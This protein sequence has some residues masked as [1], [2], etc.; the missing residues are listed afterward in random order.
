MIAARGAT[1]LG[2]ALILS[3][4][5]STSAV[6]LDFETVLP[7]YYIPSDRGLA[8]DAAGNS[9]LIASGHDNGS[10]LDVIV[11][12]LNPAGSEIWTRHIVTTDGHST[13]NDIVL[14]AANNPL[15]TGW[16]DADD[17]PAVGGLPGPRTGFR[18][19][20]ILKLDRSDGST[21][22]S[23]FLGGDYTAE[24]HAI[25]LNAAGEIYVAGSTG[26]TDFPTVNAYQNAPSAPLYIYED[27]FVAKLTPNAD[28]I[29]YSTYFGG[30]QDDKVVDLEIEAD[31]DIVIMGETTADDF[32]LVNPVQSAVARVFVS[33]FSADGSALEFSTYLGGT[34][35]DRLFAA[36][37]DAA[38]F[39]YLA[40]STQSPDFPTTAGAYQESFAG[41]INGCGAGPPFGST[42]N[43]DDGF[44]AKLAT[45]GS[46][47]V[48]STYLGGTSL[49]QTHSLAVDAAGNSYLA[50]FSSS[51]DFP[52]VTGS[53]NVVV[54]MLSADGS[55]LVNTAVHPTSTNGGYGVA[56]GA[57]GEV[58][59]S[60]QV[61]VPSELYVAKVSGM[62][63]N[64]PTGVEPA[65]GA[66]SGFSLRPNTPNPFR[67]GTTIDF[68][69]PRAADAQLRIYDA[70][71][72][73]MRTVADAA[74]AAGRHVTTWDGRDDSGNRVAAG[75]YFARLTTADG[76]TQTRKMTILR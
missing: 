71:G 23:T 8:V 28:A 50:S 65:V 25:A 9:Y 46:G 62:T 11:V 41:A 24:G 16:T 64:A 67:G 44:L 47:L 14:D 66:A 61:N 19:A 51:G 40:G 60:G 75:V 31:G 68:E 7:G 54:S 13:P 20:F 33:R 15:I 12:K 58:Y 38:G 21:I 5:G 56:L 59:F 34:D 76:L 42:Y 43:C 57:T 2:I 1:A 45:D 26:S 52:G 53:Y 48:F 29:L 72:A 63:S 17:F 35:S 27:A 37:M 73:L 18:N 32:P 39:V 6:E 70:R 55:S 3:L 22:F 74:M 69:L 36:T 4:A 49:D 30:Y 10:L